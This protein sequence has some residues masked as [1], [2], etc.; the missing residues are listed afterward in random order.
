MAVTCFGC[1]VFYAVTAHHS[2]HIAVASGHPLLR[3]RDR[4][5]G[6]L[7][8]VTTADLIDLELSDLPKA[9]LASLVNIFAKRVVKAEEDFA[10]LDIEYTQT[11]R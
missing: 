9:M 6:V 7:G 5:A 2:A 10:L 8:L 1:V 3:L 11:P 4:H